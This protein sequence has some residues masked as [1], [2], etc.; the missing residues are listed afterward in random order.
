MVILF[1]LAASISVGDWVAFV[2]EIANVI[3]NTVCCVV[4]VEVFVNDHAERV[5]YVAIAVLFWCK[6]CMYTY[7]PVQHQRCNS[8]ATR[9]LEGHVNMR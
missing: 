6:N 5:V 3:S 1:A 4:M 2:G 7:K 8:L 9:Y